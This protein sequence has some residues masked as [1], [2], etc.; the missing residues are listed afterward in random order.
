MHVDLPQQPPIRLL[1]QLDCLAFIA[2]ESLH[3]GVC[4]MRMLQDFFVDMVHEL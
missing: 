3:G 1:A 2:L 4:I